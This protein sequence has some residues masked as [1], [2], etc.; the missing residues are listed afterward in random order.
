LVGGDPAEAVHM[1]SATVCKPMNSNRLR[2]LPEFEC[3]RPQTVQEALSLLEQ[4]QGSVKAIAGGTDLLSKMKR[5]AVVPRY[6]VDLKGIPTLDFI[7]WEDDVGLKIGATATLASILESEVVNRLYPILTE[8]MAVM[9]SPQIRNAAT[10]AGNLCSA[11]PSAD[12]APPLIALKAELTAVGSRTERMIPVEDFFTAPT[13]T[14]LHPHELV[15]EILIPAPAPG[16]RGTYLKHMLR[17]EGDLAV[18]GVAV[19]LTLDSEKSVCSEVRIALGAVGPTP[20]RARKA[21]AVL[22]G[23]RIDSEL[24]EKAV[25]IASEEAR[26]IDDI[27]GSAE[28]RKEMV[29]VLTGRAIKKCLNN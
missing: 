22:M 26:P 9:A 19:Y 3:L 14:V 24:I 7:E 15:S 12:S 20:F 6:L 4:H 10:L 17:A 21:E 8:T 28:Y 1:E 25:G 29:R 5:R 18:A 11:V 2:R 13:K 16:G 23:K 27:R